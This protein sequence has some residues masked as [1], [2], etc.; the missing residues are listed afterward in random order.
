MA[1]PF[2]FPVWQHD[3]EHGI[4]QSLEDNLEDTIVIVMSS[5]PGLS[6]VSLDAVSLLPIDHIA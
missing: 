3:M 5:R 1:R 4:R 6:K 2:D